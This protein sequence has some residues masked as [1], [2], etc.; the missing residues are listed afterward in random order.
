MYFESL[1]MASISSRVILA[2]PCEEREISFY[3]QSSS[4]IYSPLKIVTC[5]FTIN[6]L[7]PIQ[8]ATMHSKNRL[9]GLRSALGIRLKERFAE[10]MKRA[11]DPHGGSG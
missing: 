5:K 1:R 6:F 7:S 4:K 11:C 9:C 2:H 3:I 8:I 10:E